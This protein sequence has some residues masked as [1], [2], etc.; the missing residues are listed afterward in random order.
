[1]TGIVIESVECFFQ[2]VP[3]HAKAFSK[4]DSRKYSNRNAP[5]AVIDLFK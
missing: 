5:I 1:M 2:D 4:P 3:D